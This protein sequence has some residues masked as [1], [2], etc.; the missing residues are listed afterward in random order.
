MLSSRLAVDFYSAVDRSFLE[1]VKHTFGDWGFNMQQ[2]NIIAF[3]VSMVVL[4]GVGGYFLNR[5]LKSRQPEPTPSNWITNPEEVQGTLDQA[6]AQRAKVEMS[7]RKESGH[8]TAS[9]S[10]VNFTPEHVIVDAPSHLPVTEAWI[11]RDVQCMFGLLAAK[12]PGMIRFH[13]FD[14]K[15]LGAK[16]DKKDDYELSLSFPDKLV[17]QQKRVHLRVEP[18]TQYVLGMALWPE[19]LDDSH[20]PEIRVKN[21]GKP[22]AKYVSGKDNPFRAINFSA[23]GLKLEIEPEVV[24]ASKHIFEIGEHY[25]L[26]LDLYEPQ[27]KS[28]TRFWMNIKVRNRFEDFQTRKLSLGFQIAAQAELVNPELIILEWHDVPEDGLEPLGNWAVQR[29]LEMFREKGVVG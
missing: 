11:G 5:Y 7:F 18:P 17:L 20:L 29:H 1:G 9:C 4:L 22:L 26:L 16:R 6:I 28:K 15:V 10:I 2:L 14:T 13:V 12:Q 25:F 23:G 3:T 21:W 19:I 27:A 8:P 24:K